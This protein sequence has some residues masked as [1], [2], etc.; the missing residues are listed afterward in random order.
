MT[1]GHIISRFSPM[2]PIQSDADSKRLFFKLY[3][4]DKG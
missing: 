1:D 4:F 3:C 2:S